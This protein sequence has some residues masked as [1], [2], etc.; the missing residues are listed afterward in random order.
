MFLIPFTTLEIAPLIAFHTLEIMDFIVFITLEIKL[1][2][3]SQ[4]DVTT[5]EMVLKTV[6]IAV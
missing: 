6:E 2:I 5:L 1:E 3:A 4:T